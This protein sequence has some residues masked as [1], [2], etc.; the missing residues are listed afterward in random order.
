MQPVSAVLLA[1]GF[2][3]IVLGGALLKTTFTDTAR[4]ATDAMIVRCLGGLVLIVA[5]IACVA[6]MAWR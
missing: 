3:A 1:A 2:A 4:L 6:A 5:G